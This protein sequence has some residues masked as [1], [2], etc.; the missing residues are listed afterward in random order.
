MVLSIEHPEAERLARELAERTGE[1][2]TDA[3]LDAV[4]ERLRRETNRRKAPRVAEELRAIRLRCSSL[5]V[6]DSSPSDEVLGYDD[7][8]VPRGASR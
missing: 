8:G 3:V 4:R 7:S 1:S 2:L 6:L 5:P